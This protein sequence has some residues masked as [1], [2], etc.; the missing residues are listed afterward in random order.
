MNRLVAASAVALG[1]GLVVGAVPQARANNGMLP[2]CVDIKS[3]GMGGAGM[4]KAT[5]AAAMARNPALIGPLG[6]EASAAFGWFHAD[7]TLETGQDPFDPPVMPPVGMLT[8]EL[9]EQESSA[10][11]FPD[12]GLAATMRLTETVSLGLALVP[13][14]GGQTKYAGGGRFWPQDDRVRV[15]YVNATPTLTWQPTPTAAYGAS[16]ILGYM[17]FESNMLTGAMAPTAGANRADREYGFGFRI[18]GWWDFGG[19]SLGVSASTPVW[20]GSLDRYDDLFVGPLNLPPVVSAGL[21]FELAEGTDIL[22]DGRYIMWDQVKAIGGKDPIE[23]G[24]GWRDQLVV[25]LGVQHRVT[26]ALTLRAGWSYGRSPIPEEFTLANA[27]FPAVTEHH[28]TAGATWHVAEQW[29]L[30]LSGYFAPRNKQTD[31]G[32]DPAFNH[33]LMGQIGA[34]T[35]LSLRQYGAMIGVRRQF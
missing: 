16:V 29:E 22:I 32:T 33:P 1:V 12:G 13:G 11:D 31:P 23:G 18:G 19:V 5:D 10:T 26:D 6:N 34:G 14:G 2:Y 21:G 4:A 8:N 15:R 3:C 9:G 27:L 25:A 28:I 7:A 20:Y 17:D 35:S 24:F 30:S